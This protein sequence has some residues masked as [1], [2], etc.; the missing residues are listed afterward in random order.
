TVLD[1]IRD[2]RLRSYGGKASNPF[3]RSAD[4]AALAE[5]LGV[6]DEEAPRRT[7]SASARVQARLTADSRWSE[8]SDQDMREWAER[9]EPTR[10]QA[11]RTAAQTARQ[12][13]EVLLAILGG[14]EPS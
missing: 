9:A 12:K 4:V 2:G 14:S 1:W 8:V 7:K 11:A 13:L 10:R 6:R 3:L 5:E